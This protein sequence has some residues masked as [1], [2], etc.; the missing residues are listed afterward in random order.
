MSHQGSKLIKCICQWSHISHDD[1]GKKLFNPLSP[2]SPFYSCSASWIAPLQCNSI[3]GP[4]P[5]FTWALLH[6]QVNN[7][8]VAMVM[9]HNRCEKRVT[10]RSPSSSTASNPA[11][12]NALEISVFTEIRSTVE[13][14]K[15]KQQK[16]GHIM[17]RA[18]AVDCQP[19]G[20]TIL[21]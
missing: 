5:G 14:L 19:L 4:T 11:Q 6:Q 2:F 20:G 7:F 10:S 8:P 12:K 13:N 9:H 18:T 16:K 3:W 21:D 15:K 1:Q 17:C